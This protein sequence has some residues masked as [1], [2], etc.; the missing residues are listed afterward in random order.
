MDQKNT[1]H[2]KL[3]CHLGQ[4]FTVD[5]LLYKGKTDYQNVMIFKNSIFGKILVI[6]DIVQTTEKDE[7][8]YHEMLTHLPIFAHNSIESVLIIGGGDGGILRE[9]CKHEHIRNI[10]MV[11]IDQKIIDLCNIFFPNH[12]NHAYEDSRVKLIID[13]GF[14]FTKITKKKFDLI[15][16]D[17]T[18]PVNYGKNL[19]LSEFYYNCK[20]CL[21]KNG[22]FVAQNGVFFLQ[23]NE[24]I[25]SY[26]I[27]NKIF[28]DTRL[29]QA[30]I[31]T[32]Y[33]G[34]MIFAWGT[35]NIELRKQSLTTL[36]SRI[37]HTKLTFNYYN[38]KI[39]I[40]SFY[41]PQYIL[42][43]LKNSENPFIGE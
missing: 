38:S 9:V 23:K 16:S 42:N 2:E 37:K 14:N 29:Y 40:S 31:P 12:S 7:F 10:T 25:S 20:N 3:Y 39:H 28:Y 21:H 19:F 11:E 34:I 26:K 41:L 36:Q 17:S 30:A 1:W 18:D 4:Y 32:Y 24:T 6:D 22:I 5:E 33:G 13:D 43:E 27:L 8:I 15:I 35:D